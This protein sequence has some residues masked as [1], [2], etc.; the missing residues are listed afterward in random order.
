[1]E[2][3]FFQRIYYRKIEDISNSLNLEKTDQAA[4]LKVAL[5]FAN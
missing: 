3:E 1:M 4:K 5:K 2:H